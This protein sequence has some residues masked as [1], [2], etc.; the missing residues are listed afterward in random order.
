MSHQ[1]PT[2]QPVPKRHVGESGVH[3]PSNGN[4]I[5]KRPNSSADGWHKRYQR[6]DVA[7]VDSLELTAQSGTQKHCENNKKCDKSSSSSPKFWNFQDLRTFLPELLAVSFRVSWKSNPPYHQHIR[8]SISGS[9]RIHGGA[10]SFAKQQP[11]LQKG[12]VV[13]E[14]HGCCGVSCCGQFLG[15]STPQNWESTLFLVGVFNKSKIST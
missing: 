7:V 11:K 1:V 15:I 9:H 10:N 5:G 3:R 13:E 6:N 12:D 14:S 4:R 2:H 8:F